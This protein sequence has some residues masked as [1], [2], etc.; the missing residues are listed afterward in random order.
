[1]FAFTFSLYAGRQA[2]DHIL[3]MFCV[4]AKKIIIKDDSPVM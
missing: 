3:P 1:M 4:K 2:A